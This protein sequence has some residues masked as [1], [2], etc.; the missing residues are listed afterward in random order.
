[1]KFKY[2]NQNW[3]EYRALLAN[4]VEC[5][6]HWASDASKG[7]YHE[8]MQAVWDA[9]LTALIDAQVTGK[10]YVMFTHGGST[11]RI[12]KTTSRSQVRK[13]MRSKEATPY[14]VRRDCIEQDTVFIAAI[15]SPKSPTG[16]AIARDFINCAK[17]PPLVK[18]EQP[19]VQTLF[20]PEVKPQ[21][22]TAK[23]FCTSCGIAV[24]KHVVKHCL[25]VLRSRLGGKIYCMDCQQEINLP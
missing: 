7:L 13:L 10:K 8:N 22:T 2:A 16:T 11:S 15:R 1:M 24:N 17:T 20:V 25:F 23:H 5:D 4:M 6:F 21:Q 9:A 18:E 19:T 14:L 3:V 12:G